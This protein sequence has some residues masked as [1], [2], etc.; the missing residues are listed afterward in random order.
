MGK[1]TVVNVGDDYSDDIKDLS[2]YIANNIHDD[3]SRSMYDGMRLPTA[4]ANH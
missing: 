2:E 1:R 3:R 4:P